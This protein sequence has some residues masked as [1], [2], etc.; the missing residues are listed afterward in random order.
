MNRA[1]IELFARARKA[2]KDI[3]SVLS[4]G[5]TSD[6]HRQLTILL[7]D[8]LANFDAATSDY[9][10][11]EIGLGILE[12]FTPEKLLQVQHRVFSQIVSNGKLVHI[13]T[14]NNQDRPDPAQ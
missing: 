7:L 6:V 3:G 14:G 1:E 8:N 2:G 9:L 5:I 11:H 10:T 13:K 12:A 4:D